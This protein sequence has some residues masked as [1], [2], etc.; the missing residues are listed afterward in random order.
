MGDGVLIHVLHEGEVHKNFLLRLWDALIPRCVALDF[1]LLLDQALLN[2]AHANQV[3]PVVRV[4]DVI[5]CDTIWESSACR[6]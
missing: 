1:C 5:L 2:V 6:D 3:S 4:L